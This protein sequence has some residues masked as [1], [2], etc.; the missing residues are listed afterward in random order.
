MQSAMVILTTVINMI[1]INAV[2]NFNKAAKLVSFLLLYTLL[3]SKQTTY[4][5]MLEKT[6]GVFYK[7]VTSQTLGIVLSIP[8]S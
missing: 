1:C 7:I 4:Y 6:L 5:T 2:I 8:N 3:K